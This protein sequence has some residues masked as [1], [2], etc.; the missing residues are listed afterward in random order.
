[1][2]TE[3]IFPPQS[4]FDEVMTALD[5]K[6]DPPQEV[7]KNPRRKNS[8][9]FLFTVLG[10]GLFFLGVL[11]YQH[12]SDESSPTS[13]TAPN[14]MTNTPIHHRGGNISP[15]TCTL[16]TYR[17]EFSNT[18]GGYTLMQVQSHFATNEIAVFAV[19]VANISQQAIRFS[20]KTILSEQGWENLEF[21]DTNCGAAAFNALENSITCP[22]KTL[23]DGEFAAPNA[24]IFRAQVNKNMKG[25]ATLK[26][27]IILS[28]PSMTASCSSTLTIGKALTTPLPSPK[29]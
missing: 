5:I 28:S 21:L 18:A 20:L 24:L 17:D 7:K 29:L 6:K 4:S 1:M 11:A 13:K 2:V 8:I 27:S 26:P 9:F 3:S 16:A 10:C 25:S 23:S 19:N 15:P 14:Q 12:A 22:P